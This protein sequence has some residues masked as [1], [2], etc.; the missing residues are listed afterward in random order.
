MSKKQ[1]FSFLKGVDALHS[2]PKPPPTQYKNNAL[3]HHYPVMLENVKT[4]MKDFLI[5]SPSA[6]FSMLDCTL[7]LGGHSLSLLDAFENL[8]MFFY[9]LLDFL[10]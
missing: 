8:Y 7:G 2:R 1:L 3:N 5:Y 9:Y 4:L 6:K 10:Q